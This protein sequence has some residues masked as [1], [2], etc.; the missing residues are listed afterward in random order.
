MNVDEGF[1]VVSFYSE[2]IDFIHYNEDFHFELLDDRQ[3]VSLEKIHPD[4]PSGDPDSW[5]SAATSS[6]YATPGLKNS[7]Y[8][9]PVPKDDPVSLFPEIFSPDMDG[10]DDFISISLTPE[11]SG[12]IENTWIC[13]SEGQ[14]IYT[15]SKN[16]LTGT[17]AIVTWDGIMD[18]GKKANPGIYVAVISLFKLDGKIKKYR[19]PFVLAVR[20]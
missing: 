17:D 10:T 18:S 5:H 14:V 3:G 1:V 16:S 19:I 11:A 6:G 8:A 13:N 20:L 15:H 7:Q 4:N 9:A 2:Q 12:Y